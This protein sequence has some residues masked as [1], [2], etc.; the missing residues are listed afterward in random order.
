MSKFTGRN[1]INT[2][3]ATTG[4]KSGTA[5]AVWNLTDHLQRKNANTWPIPKTA[6]G[7]PTS[8]VASVSSAS[9][10]SVAFTAPADN[11]GSTITSYTVTS[12]PGGFTGTGSSSPV[13]VSGLS[14]GTTYTFTATATSV[15][16][17]SGSSSASNSLTMPFAGGNQSVTD[18]KSLGDLMVYDVDQTPKSGGTLT[19]NGVSLGSY[20]YVIKNGSTTI[21]SFSNSDWFTNTQDTRSAIIKINGNLTI[22]GGITFA[23]SYRKLFTF[24]HVTGNFIHSGSISMSNMGANHSGTGNSGGAT[25]AGNILIF[26]GTHGGV[27]NPQIPATGGSGTIG[28]GPGCPGSPTNPAGTSGTNGGTGGGG[29]GGNCGNGYG[30]QGATGTSFVGGGGGGAFNDGYSSSSG[31]GAVANGGAG[32]N[33]PTTN[34]AGGAGQPGGSAG[35]GANPGGTGIGGVVIIICNGTISGSGSITSTSARGGSG[36]HASGGS[37]GGGSINVLFGTNSSSWSLDASGGS[38]QN[39]NPYGR[40]GGAGG[41]GTARMLAI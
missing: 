20:D 29:G 36:G 4:G 6:P 41:T 27:S 40:N 11:G 5:S 12:S 2:Q 22:N 23:P 32:G 28:Q 19:V 1:I 9:A 14:A 31:G 15:Y 8:L 10:A 16:G 33:G 26:S 21:S 25:T 7:A 37:A 35:S 38:W 34:A 17:T 39:S 18:L 24:I 3:P 30:G 13:I